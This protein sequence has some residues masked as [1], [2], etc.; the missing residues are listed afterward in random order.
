MRN[1]KEY[2][3]VEPSRIIPRRSRG[4]VVMHTLICVAVGLL[5]A[6]GMWRCAVAT[7][8]VLEEMFQEAKP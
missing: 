3:E 7:E 8:P 1:Y 6:A 5:L 4:E 2:C